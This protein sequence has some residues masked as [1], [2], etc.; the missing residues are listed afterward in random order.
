MDINK[1]PVNAFDVTL[2]VVL[3][4]GILRGRKHGMSEELMSLIKWLVVLIVCAFVYEPAGT[5]LAESSPF[6][7]LASF[8]IVYVTLALLI[9]GLFALVKHRLGGK[10]IGS[11]IFGRSEYYLGMGGGMVRFACV[12]LTLLAVLNARYFSP[13]EVRAMEAYQNDVYGKNY[14]PGWHTAQAVVFEDSVSGSWI[15]DHLGFLLIKATPPE[16]KSYHQKDV[17]LP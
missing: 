10:L 3:V 5:W 14:F 12:L 17:A 9:L 15:K 2:L 7:L 8:L 4:L 11:D 1:L 16:D 13:Q 6:S